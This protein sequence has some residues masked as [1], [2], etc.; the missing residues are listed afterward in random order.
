MLWEYAT[1]TLIKE[2]LELHDHAI[3]HVRFLHRSR[4]HAL[5]VDT[6][7]CAHLCTFTRLLIGWTVTRQG[8]LDGSAGIVTAAELL[9]GHG[10]SQTGGA[11]GGG[12]TVG[13]HALRGAAAAGVASGG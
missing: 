12:A 9:I 11:G 7:G 4:P 3:A 6:G 5:T 1:G 13:G 8:L 2:G 10:S